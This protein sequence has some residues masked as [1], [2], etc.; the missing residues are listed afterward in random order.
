MLLNDSHIRELSLNKHV[1]YPFAEEQLQ[2]ASYD[3]L[4]GNNIIRFVGN[5]GVID[6][7][8]K[9]LRGDADYHSYQIKDDDYY[10]LDPGEFILG[11]TEEMVTLPNNIAARFEGKSSLGRLGLAT[12]VTAGFIDPGFQGQI[13]LEIKNMNHLPIAISPGMRIGQLCFFETEPAEHPY[14]S[15]EAGSHYQHQIGPTV[16]RVSE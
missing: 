7:S 12:H 16:A 9:I 11:C 15:E 8:T 3:V 4:L 6:A 10:I 2:P 5:A 14:G 1:I 13:T